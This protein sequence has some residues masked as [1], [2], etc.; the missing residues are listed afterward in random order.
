MNFYI[1]NQNG[2]IEPR[3]C[4]SKPYSGTKLTTRYPKLNFLVIQEENV[5]NAITRIIEKGTHYPVG[6]GAT[7]SEAEDAATKRDELG[8]TLTES[9]IRQYAQS[10]ANLVYAAFQVRLTP[11]ITLNINKKP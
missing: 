10:W 9:D 5:P 8:R 6:A 3:K 4:V 1:S 11:L 7:I 2:A